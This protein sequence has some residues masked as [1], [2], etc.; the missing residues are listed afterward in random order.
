MTCYKI[1]S[2][3]LFDNISILV[4]CINCFVMIMDP[5]YDC[6][7]VSSASETEHKFFCIA[8]SVFTYLYIIEM[9][10]KIFGLGFI[11]RKGSYLRDGWNILDFVIVMSSILEMFLA[12]FNAK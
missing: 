3:Q 7:E 9:V 2:Q 4:I 8:E 10:L 1:I 12:Y 11:F 6:G 5:G